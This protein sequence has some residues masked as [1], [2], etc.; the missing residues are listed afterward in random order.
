MLYQ[1]LRAAS[2]VALRWY[3]ADVIVQ[4][5][6]RI[7]ARGPL[8]I[9]ANHPN[10]L[11]DALLVGTTIERRVLLTAKATLFEQPALAML[12]SSVGV[13]PLRRAKDEPSAGESRNVLAFQR[14]TEALQRER[15]VLIFPE[16][17]SHDEPALAPLRTGAA[18][19]ALEAQAAGANGLRV[20][21]L[22][23]VFEEKERPRSRV[24][25]R[26]GEPLEIDAWRAAHHYAGDAALLTR[27]IDARLRQV[28][29]NFATT[30]RADR[31]VRVAAALAAI[32]SAP[33]ELGDMSLFALETEIA[34]RVERATDALAMASPEIGLFADHLTQ[35]LADLENVLRARG[36]SLADARISLRVRHGA[37]FLLR[38]GI[39]A[40][41]ALP[42]AVLGRVVHWLPVRMARAFALS[43][44]RDDPSRDQPAM[45]TIVIGLGLILVWYVLQAMLIGRLL[46]IAA[47]AAWLVI[48][49]FA[50]QIDLRFS[51]RLERAWR[52]ARTYLLLRGD[53]ALRTMVLVEVDQLLDDALRLERLLTT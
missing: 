25:V 32:G 47:A 49:F 38:E 8:L 50:A 2:R 17:I 12:L 31:A 21:P 16:G 11:V 39:I 29:L 42:I 18:R 34:D 41:L 22:G 33:A 43:S 35:R 24:L 6:D 30:D 5:R 28:T 53:S 1:T 9:V 40:I 13:V 37:R 4:G 23:L 20:L 51:D 10:A 36:G 15:A 45:R 48:I 27:E 19:M 52:R 3:Y 14:V 7:P 46:G 26:I 44:L